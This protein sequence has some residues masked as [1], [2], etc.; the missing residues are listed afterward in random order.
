LEFGTSLELGATA[1]GPTQD[2]GKHF[3]LCCFFFVLQEKKKK[4]KAMASPFSS[5]LCRGACYLELAAASSKLQRAPELAF[6]SCS[7]L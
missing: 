2:P 3:S 5:S 4:K 6:L 1:A 7:K